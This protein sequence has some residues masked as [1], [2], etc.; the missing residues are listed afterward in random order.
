MS[1][2]YLNVWIDFPHMTR[3][4]IKEMLP[5]N[6]LKKKRTRD[7]LCQPAVLHLMQPHFD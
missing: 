6:Q 1:R 7:E 2:L 5:G 3:L 4:L